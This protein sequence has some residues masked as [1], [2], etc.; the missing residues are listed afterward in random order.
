MEKNLT[1]K[2]EPR[3]GVGLVVTKDGEPVFVVVKSDCLKL[4]TVTD[5]LNALN[6]K[7]N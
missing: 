5:A 4:K 6:K 2:L 3:Q 1:W 7:E